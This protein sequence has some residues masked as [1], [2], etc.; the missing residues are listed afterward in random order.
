M[1]TKKTKRLAP[2]EKA[3]GIDPR[4][5]SPEAQDLELREDMQENSGPFGL[6]VESEYQKETLQNVEYARHKNSISPPQETPDLPNI[7]EVN[8]ISPEVPDP[9]QPQA[10]AETPPIPDIPEH[11]PPVKP[12]ELGTE[13]NI[14]SSS[15]PLPVPTA[16]SEADQQNRVHPIP[17]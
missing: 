2:G 17:L 12:D 7:P 11:T 16:I 4:T 9:Y 14:Q 8:P 13:E 1:E 15:D 3:P 6:G 5:L 10:P